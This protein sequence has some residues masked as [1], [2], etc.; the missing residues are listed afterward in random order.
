MEQH[1]LITKFK[2][3]KKNVQEKLRFQCERKTVISHSETKIIVYFTARHDST[4][5]ITIRVYSKPN[6]NDN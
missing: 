1:L 4:K 6:N 3:R 5:V 2:E